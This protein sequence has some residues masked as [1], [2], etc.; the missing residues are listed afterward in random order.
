MGTQIYELSLA[1]EQGAWQEHRV[2][3]F[4]SES[5]AW[6]WVI[7]NYPNLDEQDRIYLF[8]VKEH[9]LDHGTRIPFW[10]NP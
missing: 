9:A 8:Q 1:P 3:F 6:T 2:G 5:A 10:S 7:E 4:S